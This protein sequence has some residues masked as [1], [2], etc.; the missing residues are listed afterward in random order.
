V[1]RE[2]SAD[3]LV[4][5]AAPL[6]A[7]QAAAPSAANPA[8]LAVVRFDDPIVMDDR[9]R[10]YHVRAVRSGV[11]S[12]PSPRLCLRAVDVFP[13]ATPTNLQALTTIG[14]IN[15][16]WDPNIE[17]DLGGYIVLRR[18]AGGATLLPL[19]SAPTRDPRYSDRS[20][21]PGVRYT[22][23]VRAV[24]DRVPVPNTSEPAEVGETAR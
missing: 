22:Y 21:K 5:P 7:W 16:I 20:V 12:A 1:Y 15:L 2:V 8:P 6:R 23:E 11:E 13:P 18:E 17:D 3:P 9:E 10:C 19:T 14:A 4:L 24:D